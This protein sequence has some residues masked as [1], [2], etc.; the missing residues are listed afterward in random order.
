MDVNGGEPRAITPAGLHGLTGQKLVSPD[1]KNILATDDV[2]WWLY[3]INGG[4]GLPALGLNSGDVIAGWGA[5]G[6][7]V[8]ASVGTTAP[9]KTDRVDLSTGRREFCCQFSPSDTAG[10]FSMGP[11]ILTPNKDLYG[12]GF[13]RITSSLYVMDAPK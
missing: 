7:S 1:G 6:H 8:Y 10:I 11:V 4:E 2:K 3:P 5:D 9:A 13:G 12:Y